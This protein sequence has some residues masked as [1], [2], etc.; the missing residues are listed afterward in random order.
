MKLAHGPGDQLGLA[1]FLREQ[2]RFRGGGTPGSALLFGLI[3]M[4]SGALALSGEGD[5]PGWRKLGS[6]RRPE[7]DV[8]FALR[9]ARAVRFQVAVR[10]KTGGASC[11]FMVDR[12]E[13]QATLHAI[14]Q[15]DQ[16]LPVE[17]YIPWQPPTDS[18]A[19]T[20]VLLKLRPTHWLLYL[21]GRL[22]AS[23]PAPFLASADVLV[24]GGAPAP[25]DAAF[26]FQPIS[27]IVFNSD[28]MIEEGAS[29]QLYPWTV[30]S[31]EWRIH[32]TLDE[33]LQRPESRL[34]R[35]QSRPPTPDKSPNFYCLKGK[36]SS[37]V[38]TTGHPFY[39]IYRFESS[40]QLNDGSAGL[41][42]HYI[43]PKNF[44]AFSLSLFPSPHESGFLTVWQ[45]VDGRRFELGRVRTE[46]F[47]GQWYRLGVRLSHDTI[48]CLLD[49]SP[50]IERRRPL[51]PG[52]RI[53]LFVDT[54]DHEVRFDDVSVRQSHSLRLE[55]A[56]DIAFS[57]WLK[58]GKWR[59]VQAAVPSSSPHSSE[60][61]L[62]VDRTPT[63]SRIIFGRSHH[64]DVSLQAEFETRGQGAAVGLL[65]GYQGEGHPWYRFSATRQG[66]LISYRLREVTQ[67]GDRVLDG[68]DQR[69]GVSSCEELL[70][71]V[72]LGARADAEGQFELSC[73][74]ETVLMCPV[75]APVRGGGGLFV[76]EGTAAQVRG[77]TYRLGDLP[78]FVESQQ[79]NKVYEQDSFMKH[80]ASPAGQW[81]HDEEGHL[82]H[83]GDF[84]GDFD[85]QVPAVA[86]GALVVGVPDG[87]LDGPVILRF[88]GGELELSTGLTPGNPDRVSRHQLPAGGTPTD[89]R[90]RVTLRRRGYCVR[91]ITGG[92]V[93]AAH[94]LPAPLRGSRVRVEGLSL[95]DM[96]E[97]S[98]ARH[99]VWDDY[100]E[101][102]PAKWLIN[103]GTWQV[104]NRFQCTP[105]WSHM[106]GESGSGLAALWSKYVFRGDV[107]LEFYAGMRHGWYARAGDLN[108]T[109]AADTASPDAG[110]TVTCTEWD[111][112]HS[113]NWSTLYRR[114]RAMDRSD[115]YLV[116][117]SRDG[118]VRKFYNP[119]ITHGQRPIHGAW[120][121]IKFR[122]VGR[123]LEYYFD[124]QLVFS[125]DED[126]PL[127]EG[128]VGLWT[129]M[130]SMT[131]ARVRVTFEHVRPRPQVF[132]PVPVAESGTLQE[133]DAE[134]DAEPVLAGASQH[135]IALDAMHPRWWE[136]VSDAGHSR[137]THSTANG[138]SQLLVSNRMGA[139]GMF[140]ACKLPSVPLSEIAGWQ[141][142]LQRT[143]QCP[144][145]VHYSTGIRDRAGN[146]C[147]KRRFYHRISGPQFANGVYTKTGATV[148]TPVSLLGP[149]AGT[150]VD[151]W[152]PA[153]SRPPATR[154]PRYARFEGIGVRQESYVLAGI[155]GAL[156]GQAFRVREFGP[157]FYGA[158]G[159]AWG[160]GASSPDTIRFRVPA[161]DADSTWRVAQNME[162]LMEE[163]A[164]SG[165]VGLNDAS[166][167]FGVVGRS[168]ASDSL[169][170]WIRLPDVP[171]Y[172]VAWHDE[173][174]DTASIRADGPL[175]DPRFSSLSASIGGERLLFR[176][177]EANE[178]VAPVPLG[179][180]GRTDGVDASFP[181]TVRVDRHEN[182]HLLRLKDRPANGPPVLVDIDGLTP[183]CRT[184]ETLHDARVF[185]A[186]R[187]PNWRTALRGAGTGHSTHLA[188]RNTE[189]GQR[190]TI[191]LPS[192]VS[193]ASF[194][195]LAFRYSGSGMAR[196]SASFGAGH[197][198]KLGEAV[199]SAVPVRGGKDFFLDGGW[200]TWHGM[201]S[202]AVRG[203]RL[204][205]GL[206]A[207][208]TLTFASI[209]KRDQTGRH[210]EWQADDI[211]LGPAVREAGQLRL[212]P[213][214]RD[215]DGVSSVSL[216]LV[217]GWESNGRDGG[218]VVHWLR[219]DAG[220]P[221]APGVDGLSDGIHRLLLR[222]TDVVGIES[223]TTE[224]P[225]LLDRVP[226]AVSGHVVDEADP[227]LNGVGLAL[228]VDCGDGAPW[229]A[230]RFRL[231]VG[232]R[233]PRIPAWSSRYEH[234]LPCDSAWLNYPLILRHELDQ[235]HDGDTVELSVT[236]IV[237]GAGNRAP[238]LKIPIRVDFS[239][240][241]RGPAWYY[242]KFSDNVDWFWNW[243]GSRSQTMAFT[244]A[245]RNEADV[246]H[247]P[248]TGTCLSNTAYRT[249][250][251]LSR[252][253]NWR[254][255]LFPRLS[256][257]ARLP[258]HRP[259]RRAVI[260]LV[261]E[262]RRN[263]A[264][265]L[266]LTAP[267]R[268]PRE[269]NR[270][271]QYM[272]RPD[273]WQRFSFDV[274]RM[275]RDA[276]L[277]DDAVEA[278][279]VRTL[280]VERRSSKLKERLF[281]D[282][283]FIYRLPGPNE[284]DRMIW[285]AYDAS[286][287]AGAEIAC[288]APDGTERW[289]HESRGRSVDLASLRRRSGSAQDWLR[290]RAV[291][292]PGNQST[293][294]W[295]PFPGD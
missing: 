101:E 186:V 254:V 280:R 73:D 51:P 135:G 161:S 114:G 120:Y 172:D 112:D 20:N 273:Q 115:A 232:E 86:D 119:L 198:V 24:S 249:K 225:F 12:K 6:T 30:R 174:F 283:V 58:E 72:G 284:A 75:P 219:T 91:L 62:S 26:R 113:Q 18:S 49:G 277:E 239:S 117:R 98:V 63:P 29:G 258:D 166:V 90:A 218:P 264:Y 276:G 294:F 94:R 202:D 176:D 147:V 131:V 215:V 130:N 121:Y 16:Q 77:L 9:T 48:C 10:P 230:G 285:Y 151:V 221:L 126:A 199:A 134:P 193:T 25:A 85:I 4:T 281:L 133:V 256:F 5:D 217:S 89:E 152:I 116:P 224:I 226:P 61:V 262:T 17:T 148:I 253:V 286:G 78:D 163:L 45:M 132:E 47:I 175:P 142:R 76:G 216:A 43:D 189:Y 39:D 228:R 8:T 40:V 201:A 235:A 162:A 268:S 65:F 265:T 80:W 14:G 206:F 27:E 159:I 46:L 108:C 295:V 223:R 52:G 56:E 97:T 103:G 106:V 143:A 192:G 245:R 260:R 266:S 270:D 145:N 261:L 111:R 107:T 150:R 183:F 54:T 15:T 227:D 99:N 13:A 42:F 140:L 173:L 271:Q 178:W 92:A 157:V 2:R 156:P 141:L 288:V 287:V 19:Q 64:V 214:Y 238:R 263:G 181:V 252:A 79:R 59:G 100:F 220:M 205:S 124:N 234:A 82:W 68:W 208:E 274:G 255:G 191:E 22:N 184:F 177:G 190:L 7:G 50:A 203:K 93:L 164:R 171:L 28:F 211:V 109:I 169:L 170:K 122:R 21:D 31:G 233:H 127:T 87:Q 291:D 125:Q 160:A 244:Q 290:V 34:E 195:L 41:V 69:M 194:P 248:D 35:V 11:T 222:A 38:I 200:H 275:L 209:D 292:Q 67:E 197:V 168:A 83:K 182:T 105:S 88:T 196:I 123:R 95:D 269:L 138:L 110:Y 84:L 242:V 188:V 81:I 279:V 3:C 236:G 118:N 231:L 213:N 66:D 144:I 180:A 207:S 229:E 240:D 53:G 153:S 55:T 149:G 136:V 146:Y 71:R 250:G 1:L 272:W 246:V 185:G 237:D 137:L 96:Q 243:D 293:A 74:G 128:M 154:Q 33:A 204:T 267:T 70:W 158:E 37:S 165:A 139:G 23:F 257:R 32:T 104:I 57:T 129:F 282:D 167:R 247:L 259:A 289:Q 251:E 278:A 212:T 44:Y 155:G 187:T 179:I 241:H 36:G 60:A 102:A 210:S